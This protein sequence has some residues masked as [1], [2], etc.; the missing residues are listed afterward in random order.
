MPRANHTYQRRCVA[1]NVVIHGDEI[2]L[3]SVFDTS[4]E[5][6]H[7]LCHCWLRVLWLPFHKQYQ[8]WFQRHEEP[9]N[10]TEEYEQG[11]YRFFDYESTWYVN[12]FKSIL[13][14]SF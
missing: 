7:V 10:I 2:L 13:P 4:P 3:L 5:K 11:T 8:T 6:E 9:K 14:F 12:I 1:R